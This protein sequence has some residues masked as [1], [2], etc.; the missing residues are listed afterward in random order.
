[1]S[2]YKKRK[3]QIPFDRGM[4]PH[5]LYLKIRVYKI[6]MKARCLFL[7]NLMSYKMKF[8]EEPTKLDIKHLE[9][10]KESLEDVCLC[11]MCDGKIPQDEM[12][13]DSCWKDLPKSWRRKKVIEL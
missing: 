12:I 13:C 9:E 1:M 8:T 5:E 10:I 4:A 7:W 6:K 2:H 11:A 3:E